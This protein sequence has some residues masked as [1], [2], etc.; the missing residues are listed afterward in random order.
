MSVRVSA[1]RD[2][3]SHSP[4]P[5]WENTA[6][7]DAWIH[8]PLFERTGRAKESFTGGLLH[9]YKSE[10]AWQNGQVACD[11]PNGGISI[12]VYGNKLSCHLGTRRGFGM[13]FGRACYS[14][15]RIRHTTEPDPSADPVST[16]SIPVIHRSGSDLHEQSFRSSTATAR[17]LFSLP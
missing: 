5:K 17:P 16:T 11:K 7:E 9:W 15:A 3:C 1:Q 14:K 2:A 12:Q 13:Q 4:Q 6:P 8:P 10:L